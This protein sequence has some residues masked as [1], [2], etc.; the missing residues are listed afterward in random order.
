MNSTDAAVSGGATFTAA[1]PR[2]SM[3]SVIVPVTERPEPLAEL[4]R[5]YAAPLRAAGRPF[6]FLFG[7]EPWA[8]GLAGPV[9]A[10]ADAGEPVRVLEVANS[11]GETTLLKALAAR[12]RGGIV[13]TLPAY[14]RVESAV[15]PELIAGVEQGADMVLARRWPRRDSWIN[16]IQNR[17]FHALVGRVSGGELHDIACGVRAMR[18]DVLL[19]LPVY[20]DLARFLPLFAVREGYDVREVDAP[21]HRADVRTRIYG[22]GTYLRRL[23]DLLGLF[24]LM[25]FTDKPL[26]FFGLIGSTLLLGGAA[27]LLVLFVQRIGGQGIANRPFLLLGSLLAV[28]GVQAIALGLVGEIIVYLHAPSRRPYRL[29]RTRAARSEEAAGTPVAADRQ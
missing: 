19:D 13:I 22:A 20:G 23:L 26:R 12:A 24:F 1:E 3:V 17:L 14:R 5:E 9:V 29:A 18:R 2:A 7:C 28:L 21:Q 16:R 11:A 27:L 8:R 4:Y 10:L 15:L 25:R 6:E